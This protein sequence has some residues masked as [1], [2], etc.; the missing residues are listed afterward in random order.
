M[1]IALGSIYS[2][3]KGTKKR[4]SRGHN[5]VQ[6]FDFFVQIPQKAQKKKKTADQLL[7]PC[8]KNMLYHICILAPHY[9]AC[10]A[11][12]RRHPHLEGA[13]LEAGQC[14][15][16]VGLRDVAVQRLAIV[17]HLQFLP[18]GKKK[19]KKSCP[20]SRQSKSVESTPPTAGGIPNGVR[21]GGDKG[22]SASC[23]GFHLI[24]V[25]QVNYYLR[26]QQHYRACNKTKKSGID[27]SFIESI[28]LPL[29]L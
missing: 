15:L 4:T 29:I 21:R 8:Q 9:C 23:Q 18:Q 3:R 6:F 25:Q 17:R 20:V 24:I 11:A 14:R 19:K 2:T 13:L 28:L 5:E 22:T 27:I 26:C 16:P 1:F 12:I 7:Q 10:L